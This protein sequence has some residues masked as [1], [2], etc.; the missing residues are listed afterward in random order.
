M[1]QSSP[2]LT[3]NFLNPEAVVGEFGVQPGMQVADFGSGA[4]HIA[5]LIAQRIGENGKLVALDI[6]EDKLDAVRVKAKAAGLNNVET[7]R[8]N[9]EV[10]GSTGLPDDSQDL[11][12]LVNILFQSQKKSEIFKEAKR[13]LKPAGR[14]VLVEW[15]KAA[16]GFGPPD[17]L[18]I[19]EAAMQSLLTAEGLAF[20]HNFSAGQYHYGLSFKKP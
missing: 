15:K 1:V 3:D 4:G 7:V 2:T 18:R 16:G 8:A 13:V 17:E 12:V 6:L 14:L 19:D 5:I 20:E 9:L 11:V 10:I